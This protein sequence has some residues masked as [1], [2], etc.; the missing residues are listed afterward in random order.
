MR[1]GEDPGTEIVATGRGWGQL[2]WHP[3]MDWSRLREC[4]ESYRVTE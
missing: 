1:A 4:I 2:G 3:V